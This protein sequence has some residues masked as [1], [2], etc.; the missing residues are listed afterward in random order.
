MHEL[1]LNLGLA[2]V[3]VTVTLT[4]LWRSAHSRAERA[5]ATLRQIALDSSGRVAPGMPTTDVSRG[6]DAI[7]LEVERIAEGQR[8]TTKLL[9]ERRDPM[10]AGRSITPH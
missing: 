2:F 6:L 5:E 4:C 3:P 9:A 7:M 1:M 8:F 10:G